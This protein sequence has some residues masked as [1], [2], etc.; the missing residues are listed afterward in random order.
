MNYR[1]VLS[2]IFTTFLAFTVEAQYFLTPYESFSRQKKSYI[3]MDDGTEV[4][5]KIKKIKRKKGLIEEISIL[6]EKGKKRSIKPAGIRFMY[7]PPSGLDQLN[8]SL[9]KVYD[10]TQ[11]DDVELE[12]DLIKD[13]YAYFE[14][15]E[16]F[17]KKKK[18]TLLMQLLNPTSCRKMRVYHD[19]LAMESASMGIG[20]F[21]MAG[22]GDKSYYFKKGDETAVRVKKKNYRS[23]YYNL[24][25]HCSKLEQ[26][27]KS[28]KWQDVEVHVYEYDKNCIE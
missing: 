17:V 3:T 18:R 2:L 4:I 23:L 12:A 24:Y 27:I 22:G 21:T 7:L 9:Q 6:D 5:G 8:R 10:A 1:L 11:W 26:D 28:I 20:G 19:P 15:A 25:G 14:Q 13:G 16:V